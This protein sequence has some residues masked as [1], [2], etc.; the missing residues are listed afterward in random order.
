MRK[1]I[2][3]LA[4]AAAL[5][6]LA[7]P[8]HAQSYPPTTSGLTVSTSTVRAGGSLTLSGGGASPG[9]TVTFTLARSASALG[10][11]VRRAV[12]ATAGL[13]RLVAAV[14]PLAAGTVLGSTTA[15]SD[16]SFAAAVHIPSGLAAG[17]YTVSASSGGQVLAVATVQ[18]LAASTG[19]TG[20]LPFT[21]ANLL[22]GLVVGAVLITAGG[23]LLLGVK[24]RR[25]A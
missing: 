16:G 21:G 23:L 19:G 24:R 9:A 18:V 10:G 2:T 4:A 7:I 5:T 13:A 14:R 8:A 15:G 11:P 12:A 25:T 6:L 3:L 1:V 20:G 22:P 17:L